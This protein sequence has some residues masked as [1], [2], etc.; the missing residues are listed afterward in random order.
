MS[1]PKNHSLIEIVGNNPLLAS[2]VDRFGISF[3]KWS[4]S[5]DEACKLENTNSDLLAEMLRIFSIGQH[6]P[7]T[8]LNKLPLQ[9]IIEYLIKTH[10]YYINRKLPR[11]EKFIDLLLDQYGMFDINLYLL[12]D[13]FSKYKKDMADH[14]CIEECMLFPYVLKL[15]KA[16]NEPFNPAEL[17]KILRE[18]SISNFQNEH[19]HIEDEL[20][21]IRKKIHHYTLANNHK[22]QTVSLLHELRLFETDLLM[23]GRLEEEVLIPRARFIEGELKEVLLNKARQN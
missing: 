22:F 4:L 2:V 9:D 18:D 19:H 20:G 23:H 21:E 14:I 3:S 12:K 8:E 10:I 16:Q 15:L 7:L 6:F 1:I 11:L 5:V 13:Y 17:Y